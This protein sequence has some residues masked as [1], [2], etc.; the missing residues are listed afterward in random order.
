MG[1]QKL[2]FALCAYALIAA[3]AAFTLEE[4]FRYA[5]WV[6]MGGLALK[7]LVASQQLRAQ[8]SAQAAERGR[9]DEVDDHEEQDR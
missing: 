9:P 4:K 5:I 6:L 8:H 2:I 1:K 7:T 3:S